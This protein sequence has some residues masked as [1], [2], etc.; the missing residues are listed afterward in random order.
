MLSAS[1]Q[2]IEIAATKFT[3]SA[4]ADCILASAGWLRA[5]CRCS[6]QLPPDYPSWSPT[7]FTWS[8]FPRPPQNLGGAQL[9]SHP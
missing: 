9:S 6:F 8:R 2:A 5:F 3:K 7:Y 4:F 1:F